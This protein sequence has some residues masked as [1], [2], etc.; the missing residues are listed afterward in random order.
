MS[1]S[2]TGRQLPLRWYPALVAAAT[3]VG[4]ALRLWGL[5]REPLWLD[6]IITFERARLPLATLV[7]NAFAAAHEPT[8][9]LLIHAWLP[10]DGGERSL[11]LPSVVFGTLTIPLA[12]WLG[13]TI[14]GRRAG[15]ASALLLAVAPFQVAYAQEARA[16]TLLTFFATL[17]MAGLAALLFG[18]EPPA[19]DP[20]GRR[21]RRRAGLAAIGGTIGATAT[22]NSGLFLWAQLNLVIGVWVARGWIPA[23]RL[24][25]RWLTAQPAIAL[26]VLLCLVPMAG[27]LANRLERFW[28]P[29]PTL[30]TAVDATREVYLN[31]LGGPVS[32]VA[33]LGIV[34]AVVAGVH[35]LRRQAPRLTYLALSTLFLP[36]ASLLVSLVRPVFLARY[37]IW[38]A[39]PFLVLAGCGL[40]AVASPRRFGAV[41]GLVVAL[42]MGAHAE[43]L[44]RE[45]KPRWDLAAAALARELRAGDLIVVDRPAD[46]RS[47][48]FYLERAGYRGGG[49]SVAGLAQDLGAFAPEHPRA[50]AL[51]VSSRGHVGYL[52]GRIPREEALRRLQGF[53]T[54]QEERTFGELLRVVTVEAA[55]TP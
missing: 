2:A 6:E 18:G 36:V 5:G 23:D 47:I 54:P 8:Y 34:F 30:T 44:G 20:G 43:S 28:V 9:F 38:S 16:Y 37:L 10:A 27:T 3:L 25:H 33:G 12:A 52:A 32:A 45:T 14:A 55:R 1:T 31:H 24:L 11:R 19:Q 46:Y 4:G 41:L 17:A 51:V 53:G 22:M 39:V 42:G 21:S 7:R 35:A 29:A 48:R 40:A 26:V 50:F 13:T 49:P 15:V